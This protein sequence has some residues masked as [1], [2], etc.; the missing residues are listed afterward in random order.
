ETIQPYHLPVH[1]RKVTDLPIS[2]GM[3][4]MAPLREI[5]RE[6]LM[7]AARICNGNVTHMARV[8]GMGRT[9]VWRRLARWDISLD[10]FRKGQ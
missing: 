4:T 3:E 7:R 5:E 6:A 10:Q 8:L 9:T 2:S 1:L